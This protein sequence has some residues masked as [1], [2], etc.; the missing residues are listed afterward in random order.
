M[1]T[2]EVGCCHTPF[3]GL[4]VNWYMVLTILIVFHKLEHCVQCQFFQGLRLHTIESRQRQCNTD[5]P[6]ATKLCS[7]PSQC[8]SCWCLSTSPF[9][10]I[11]KMDHIKPPKENFSGSKYCTSGKTL[12]EPTKDS[13]LKRKLRLKP[14]IFVFQ[15][16]VFQSAKKPHPKRST[17]E[18]LK[19]WFRFITPQSTTFNRLTHLKVICTISFNG[20]CYGLIVAILVESTQPKKVSLLKKTNKTKNN[21]YSCLKPLGTWEFKDHI[22]SEN[23]TKAGTPWR[24]IPFRIHGW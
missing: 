12:I 8:L 6:H 17:H 1:T 10:L 7:S 22:L 14:S 24:I 9:V 15:P 2:L 20:S 3:A 18:T 23:H 21:Y 11:N 19:E 16:L 5:L 4:Y 13:P